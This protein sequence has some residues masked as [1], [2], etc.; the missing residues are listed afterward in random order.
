M[1][2]IH[3]RRSPLYPATPV[4]LPMFSAKAASTW[5]TRR[6]PHARG[7]GSRDRRV[8]EETRLGHHSHGVFR[9]SRLPLP[10]SQLPARY[11]FEDCHRGGH[12]RAGDRYRPHPRSA[13]PLAPHRLRRHSRCRAKKS[14]A[15]GDI[16]PSPRTCQPTADNRR[17]RDLSGGPG[18][19][20]RR[21]AARGKHVCRRIDKVSKNSGTALQGSAPAGS[22][23][24]RPGHARPA[25][26]LGILAVACRV[27][28]QFNAQAGSR[29]LFDGTRLLGDDQGQRQRG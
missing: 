21:Y 19:S 6:T 26:C 15:A 2:P 27:R 25:D 7:D 8:H 22:N 16:L 20:R 3:S 23:I 29:R 24:R 5:S 12:S 9:R 14:L 10:G 11:Q 1:A 13:D 4:P 28:H 17:D 18:G